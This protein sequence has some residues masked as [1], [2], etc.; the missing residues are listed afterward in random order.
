MEKGE[1]YGVLVR[2]YVFVCMYQGSFFRAFFGFVR[3]RRIG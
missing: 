2:T 1:G 3:E